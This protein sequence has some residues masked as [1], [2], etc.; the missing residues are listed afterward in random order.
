MSQKYDS[1]APH[2]IQTDQLM[3]GIA[4]PLFN[5]KLNNYINTWFMNY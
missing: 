1:T 4:N 3:F 5:L 2:L